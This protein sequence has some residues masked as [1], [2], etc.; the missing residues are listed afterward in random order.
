M[1]TLEEIKNIMVKS[2]F[3]KEE[4]DAIISNLTEALIS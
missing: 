4:E 1:K 2:P 3:S